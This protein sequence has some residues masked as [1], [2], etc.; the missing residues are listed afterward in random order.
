MESNT[1]NLGLFGVTGSIGQHVLHALSKQYSSD[2]KVKVLSARPNLVSADYD[3]YQGSFLDFLDNNDTQT[4]DDVNSENVPWLDHF[5]GITRAFIILPQSLSSQEMV[6]VGK[7]MGKMLK[8][9]GCMEVI[10]VSSYGI[11]DGSTV[12]DSDEC[13]QGPLGAA[14][15]LIEQYYLSLGIVTLSLRPSSFFSNLQ[16]SL[17]SILSEGVYAS[18]IGANCKVNWVSPEDIA[19]VAVEALMYE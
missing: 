10:R 5:K 6:R 9:I 3:V 16:F 12:S 15:L 1:V 11:D 14:H 13:P 7:A 19:E 18:P 4:I 17:G 8:H 2:K